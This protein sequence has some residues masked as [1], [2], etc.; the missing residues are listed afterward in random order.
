M[1]E[2]IERLKARKERILNK[3]PYE[4]IKDKLI[5]GFNSKSRMDRVL[6]DHLNK[7]NSMSLNKKGV[8]NK[9]ITSSTHYHD[10]KCRKKADQSKSF[11]N[12]AG[13]KMIHN[14]K[15]INANFKEVKKL[16]TKN[17]DVDRKVLNNYQSFTK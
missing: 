8:F 15:L 3:L 4:D 7:L 13:K 16:L 17:V 2:G 12:E 9:P 1:K 6:N 10:F 14:R 11:L 5:E